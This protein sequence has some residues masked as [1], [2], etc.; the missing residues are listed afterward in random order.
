MVL[1]P[2]LLL[3][4]CS[5]G[6]P[7]V[8]ASPEPTPESAPPAFEELGESRP[9]DQMAPGIALGRPPGLRQ[10]APEGVWIWH[11]DD[12]WHLRTTSPKRPHH[13]QGV[14][15]SMVGDD[16]MVFDF[17]THGR[18]DGLDWKTSGAAC[19]WF[20]ITIDGEGTRDA[21]R[22]G[23]RSVSPERHMFQLCLK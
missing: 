5:A 7:A 9:S 11:D 4:A 15:W 1:L 17:H 20:N 14:I 3:G 8:Y 13:F 22:I 12:G 19:V 18:E 6:R 16:R 23:A 10:D 2:P 21:V